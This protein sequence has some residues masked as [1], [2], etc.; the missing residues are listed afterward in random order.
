VSA[1]RRLWVRFRPVD[2]EVQ[3]DYRLA[4][5][6]AGETASGLGAHFWAFEVDGGNGCIE[7]LEGPDDAGLASLDRIA[8]PSLREAA[9]GAGIAGLR[10]AADGLRCGEIR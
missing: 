10:I 5:V 4:A 8:E 3:D 1:P 6:A 9:G 2:P 7:F